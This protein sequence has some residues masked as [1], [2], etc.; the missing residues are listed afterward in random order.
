ME[1]LAIWLTQQ[2]TLDKPLVIPLVE[3]TGV[4]SGF[5]PS[6]EMTKVLPSRTK[7]VIQNEVRDIGLEQNFC[8]DKPNGLSGVKRIHVQ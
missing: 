6:V 1:R 3:T 8:D 5:L 2:K 7:F 4:L